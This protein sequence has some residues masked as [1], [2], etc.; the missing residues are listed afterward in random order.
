[1]VT[2]MPERTINR[3]VTLKRSRFPQQFWYWL[4]KRRVSE[5]LSG[6]LDAGDFK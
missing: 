6:G 3:S 2:A 1:M 4:G 5:L